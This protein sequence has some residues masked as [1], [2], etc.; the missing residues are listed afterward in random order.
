M[1]KVILT[2][3]LGDDPKSGNNV[4]RV[5]L[6]TTERWKDRDG[7]P[8]ERTDWHRIV[9]FGKLAEIADKYL[10]KGRHVLI[11]GKIHYDKYTDQHGIERYSTDIIADKMEILDKKADRQ[12]SGNGAWQ[13]QRKTTASDYRRAKEGQSPPPSP[14]QDDFVDDD[15]PF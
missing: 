12:N 3:H 2:G 15:I 1:N 5:G 13:A 9:F 8:Q 14:S 11:E 6:A 7:Q 4:S 10:S